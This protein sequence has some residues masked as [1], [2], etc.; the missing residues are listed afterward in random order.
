MHDAVKHLLQDHHGSL[1]SGGLSSEW[2]L[3]RVVSHQVFSDKSDVS[4]RWSLIRM[5]YGQGGLSSGSFSSW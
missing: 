3:S 5:V 4:P 1:L 2:S